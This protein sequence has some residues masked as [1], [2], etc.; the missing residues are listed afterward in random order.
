MSTSALFFTWF[1][2]ATLW[3]VN[4]LRRPVPPGRRFPPMWLAG[5]VVSELAPWLLMVRALIAWGF[6]VLGGLDVTIGRLG[7]GLFVVSE[8]GLLPLMA[9]TLRSSSEAGGAASLIGLFRIGSRLPSGVVKTADLPY[10]AELTLDVYRRPDTIRCP[11][12][13][14]CHIPGPGCEAVREAG[15]APDPRTGRRGL[16]SPRH[17]LPALARRHVP[18]A[19]DRREAGNC[20]GQERGCRYWGWIR[21]GWQSPAGP[22]G[23]ISPRSPPSRGTTPTCNLASRRRTPR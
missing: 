6:M 15:A 5:M 17:S 19:P 13:D 7:L 16:G 21:A 14:L 18:R 1:F 3:T 2:A 9:R 10:A 22:R 12:V 4:A 8:I 11:H 20:L 23:R